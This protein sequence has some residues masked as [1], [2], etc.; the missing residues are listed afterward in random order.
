M[1]P[2]ANEKALF[3]AAVVRRENELLREVL[4]G[5]LKGISALAEVATDTLKQGK[6]G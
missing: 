5:L 4:T 3:D 6:L 2:S 1:K